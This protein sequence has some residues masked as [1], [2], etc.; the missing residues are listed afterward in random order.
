MTN[1]MTTGMIR[2]EGLTIP[3][4]MKQRANNLYFFSLSLIASSSV[5][6]YHEW[7]RHSACC[8]DDH[9]GDVI[10]HILGRPPKEESQPFHYGRVCVWASLVVSSDR[11]EFFPAPTQVSGALLPLSLSQSRQGK[12]QDTS[13]T[14]RRTSDDPIYHQDVVSSRLVRMDRP[15]GGTAPGARNGS[16]DR[17]SLPG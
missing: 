7:A 17:H 12:D 6:T 2:V 15:C 16:K 3:L 1:T 13:T 4:M 8:I 9:Y 5:T 11:Q 10:A 14:Y